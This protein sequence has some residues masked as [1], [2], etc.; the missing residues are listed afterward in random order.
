M[1]DGSVMGKG[2]GH[3]D[4]SVAVSAFA[5]RRPLP[6]SV[7][8]AAGCSH[9]GGSAAFVLALPRTA[10]WRRLVRHGM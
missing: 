10:G 8:E 3:L 2:P 6:R 1:V 9:N 4:Y 5:E 7:A